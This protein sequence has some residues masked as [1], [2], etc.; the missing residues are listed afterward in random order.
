MSTWKHP[1]L[2]LPER[3]I[4]LNE[5]PWEFRAPRG[6][7]LCPTSH[8]YLSTFPACLPAISQTD[9]PLKVQQIP[10]GSQYPGTPGLRFRV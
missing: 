8:P 9:G 2:F 4:G 1:I 10:Q 5:S 7:G 3:S 6:G